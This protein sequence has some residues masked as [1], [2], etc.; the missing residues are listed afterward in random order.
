[1]KL[2]KIL[3][4]V[5]LGVCLAVAAIL[6]VG[7]KETE[8]AYAI[9]VMQEG[10]GTVVAS[11]ATVAAGGSVTFTVKPDDGYVCESFT[12][13]GGRVKLPSTGVYVVPSVLRPITAQAVFKSSDVTVVGYDGETECL[14][15]ARNFGDVIGTLPMPL[16]KNRRPL[17]WTYETGKQVIPVERIEKT[18]TLTLKLVAEDVPTGYAERLTPKGIAATY[19]DAAA[20]KYG[21]TFQTDAKPI[22]PCVQ[23]A[24]TADGAQPD[25]TAAETF[26]AEYE[27][28]DR[29][30]IASAVVENLAFDTRYAV[31]V[32]DA[33][34]DTWSK[35]F[36]FTT[37][38]SQVDVSKFLFL[39]A[40]AEE[41][42]T[43]GGN[44]R[45]ATVMDAAT[46]NFPDAQF[47]LHGGSQV[48]FG[49]FGDYWQ[50]M[51]GSVEDYLF[52]MP[53]MAISGVTEGPWHN[54]GYRMVNSIFNVETSDIPQPQLGDWYSFDYGPC[55]VVALRTTDSDW[56]YGKLLK[57]QT[58]WLENDLANVD[59]TVTPW[60]VVMVHKSVF[61]AE[62]LSADNG[63]NKLYTQL[64]PIL[65]KGNVDLLLQGQGRGFEISNP[66]R[67]A[68][69]MSTT[70]QYSGGG[71]F[72]YNDITGVGTF[73][74]PSGG[75][76]PVR[77]AT[78]A[79]TDR[80]LVCMQTAPVGNLWNIVTENIYAACQPS[81]AGTQSLFATY[82][83]YRD[84]VAGK[85]ENFPM[86]SYI[87]ATK[88]ALT[89]KSYAV[90][91]GASV[92]IDGIRL[93]KG[94]A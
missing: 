56:D 93:T 67:Y 92:Y 55:H 75:V 61:T 59:R 69:G 36:T 40:S 43:P 24:A 68:S 11:S 9:S 60:V 78:Y 30:Y 81:D 44:T 35:T 19:F 65:T 23:V 8:S 87:E 45:Y 28:Y 86:Y 4:T 32:G 13:N 39:S 77:T 22:Y 42:Y 90:D 66:V 49:S 64:M 51:L 74:A 85:D 6:P 1:M 91:A 34:V 94:E 72:T 3:Q 29:G 83:G 37:R 48:A 14:R 57:A 84:L 50:H 33:S 21:V 82:R 88:D 2:R 16:L 41:T 10:S 18:G 38:K 26:V 25:F 53:V 46:D 27:R 70:V 20:T 31:R 15:V 71:S 52:R 76:E 73:D 47:V 80:G 17:Y 63:R 54:M 12:L 58:D 89:L 62:N 79:G 5:A 7:C